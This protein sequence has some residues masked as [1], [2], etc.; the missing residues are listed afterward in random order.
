MILQLQIRKAEPAD[1]ETIV[2]FNAQLARETEGRTLEA[3]T[4]REGVAQVLADPAK[5]FYWVVEIKGQI[6]GQLLLTYE[7]SDWRN[8]WF[9]W[10][11]SVYVRQEWRGRGVFT[12]LYGFVEQEASSRPD[13]CGLRLYVE[14]DNARARQTYERLGM[15]PTS[16][17]VYEA[18][19]RTTDR[20]EPADLFRPAKHRTPRR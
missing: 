19:F 17:Q 9:W 1:L 8:G 6:V 4:L 10:I 5:G 3:A 15:K 12:E 20:G 14:E 7:W 16:Y 2:E 13:V 18:D 11:Q